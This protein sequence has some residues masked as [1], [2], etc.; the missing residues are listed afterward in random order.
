[1]TKIIALN[2]ESKIY[3]G[4]SFGADSGAI[5]VP[6]CSLSVLRDFHPNC[7]HTLQGINLK[8]RE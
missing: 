3:R 8:A 2:L 1:M 4:V 7:P 6:I 5:C